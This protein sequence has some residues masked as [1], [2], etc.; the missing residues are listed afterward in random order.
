MQNTAKEQKTMTN[1]LE[2]TNLFSI[3]LTVSL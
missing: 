2:V 3:W 1:E